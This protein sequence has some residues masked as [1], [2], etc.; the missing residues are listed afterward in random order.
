MSKFYNTLTEEELG[1]LIY[2]KGRGSFQMNG[3]L[4]NNG[5]KEEDIPFIFDETLKIASQEKCPEFK[6]PSID[7]LYDYVKY[8]LDL[9]LNYINVLDDIFN[10]LKC[11]KLTGKEKLY[12]GISIEK[13][14]PIFK[15]KK[16]DKY[17]FPTF[18][19]TSLNKGIAENFS[20]AMVIKRFKSEKNKKMGYIIFKIS[21]PKD[22]P[23][24]YIP[25]IRLKKN[26]EFKELK[27][28]SFAYELFEY[29]LPRNLEFEILNVEDS[30][31]SRM[32]EKTHEELIKIFGLDK[33][34]GD[35]GDDFKNK[36]DMIFGKVKVIECKI[37][38]R[39]ETKPIQ[40]LKEEDILKI[41]FKINNY[42]ED[43]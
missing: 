27:K 21:N 43:K 35:N 40:K 10:K 39:K 6:R 17:T 23:Y 41:N 11:P 9:R 42:N 36:Y 15:L 13:S 33:S 26:K 4:Y 5:F 38:N 34:N 3:Y 25:V 2:Y 29:L 31:V 16:G 22:I 19:P 8:Y 37:I 24:L 18:L 30:N 14:N 32:S 12:R 1:G 28:I 7:R 20:G